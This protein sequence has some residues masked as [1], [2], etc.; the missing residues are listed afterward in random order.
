MSA[1]HELAVLRQEVEEVKV[2]ETKEESEELSQ[3]RT[4]VQELKANSKVALSEPKVA[5]LA[6][7]RSSLLGTP[8]TPAENKLREILLK[9]A[10][11]TN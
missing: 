9:N 6:K 3:L 8:L 1:I 7:P 2:E 11:Q 4:E 5:E 10:N